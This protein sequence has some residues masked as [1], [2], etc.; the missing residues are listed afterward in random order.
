MIKGILLSLALVLPMVADA[1]P[2][3]KKEEPIVHLTDEQI[4]ENLK[5]FALI[6]ETAREN[7]VDEVDERKK[8]SR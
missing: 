5:K 1:A 4:Y 2:K 6:F 3:K 8:S 7:F